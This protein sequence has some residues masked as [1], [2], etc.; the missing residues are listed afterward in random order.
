M[1]IV[2]MGV[3]GSGKTTV[4][5]MLSQV[6]GWKYFDAD[7]FHPPAN[8]QK[9]KRGIPLNDIDRMPWLQQLQLIL[10]QS[11]DAGEPAILACSALTQRYRELLMIDQR[12]RLVYLKGDHTLIEERLR[13]RRNHYMNPELLDS[14]FETLEEPTDGLHVDISSSP[15]AIVELI[16][17]QFG[18]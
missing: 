3:T 14:Q 13:E 6:L 9:M 10:K 4:G 15:Q 16:R 1:I 17:T 5:R 11:L 18:V 8:I 7:D 12:L 2:V